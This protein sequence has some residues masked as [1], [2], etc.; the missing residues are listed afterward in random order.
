MKYNIDAMINDGLT[1]DQISQVIGYDYTSMKKDGLNQDQINQ[2]IDSDSIQS[3]DMSEK[4]PP[5]LSGETIS[6]GEGMLMHGL[7]KVADRAGKGFEIGARKIQEPILSLGA[8]SEDIAT[9]TGLTDKTPIRDYINYNQQQ[10][11]EREKE[12][13]YKEGDILTPSNVSGLATNIGLATTPIKMPKS[14]SF[15]ESLGRTGVKEMNVTLAQEIGAGKTYEEAFD[16]SAVTGAMVG[17]LGVVGAGIYKGAKILGEQKA[18]KVLRRF[19]EMLAIT[20]ERKGELVGNYAKLMGIEPDKMTNSDIVTAIAYGE[21]NARKILESSLSGKDAIKYHNIF[22]NYAKNISKRVEKQINSGSEVDISKGV[23]EANELLSQAWKDYRHIIDLHYGEKFIDIPMSSDLNKALF[24]IADKIGNKQVKEQ[25]LSGVYGGTKV[26]RLGLNEA[27]EMKQLIGDILF[28]KNKAV[29]SKEEYLGLVKDKPIYDELVSLYEK[30]LPPEAKKMYETLNKLTTLKAKAN[31]MKLVNTFREK[32]LNIV[33][34]DIKL[35]ETPLKAKQKG[36]AYDSMIKLFGKRSTVSNT[37]ER[38]VIGNMYKKASKNGFVDFNKL[39]DDV[40]SLNLKTPDGKFL[41]DMITRYNKS[42]GN[43]GDL[44]LY[45][46]KQGED[47]AGLATDPF[48]SG[49][50]AINKIFYNRLTEFAGFSRGLRASYVQKKLPSVLDMKR[51]PDDFTIREQRGALA[52][53]R[54]FKSL[55]KMKNTSAEEAELGAGNFYPSSQMIGETGSK[56]L[57]TE[58][59]FDDA[60]RIFSQSD[61][62]KDGAT[63]E[64]WEKTGWFFDNVDDRWKFHLDGNNVRLKAN[65][66]L[67]TRTGT[68]KLQDVL[69]MPEIFKAY[70]ELKDVKVHFT[71]MTSTSHK[72]WYNPSTGEIGINRDRN[73]WG[74]SMIEDVKKTLVHEIQH[75]IQGIEGFAKGGSP[76]MF[77][78]DYMTA[79]KKYQSLHGE[80]EARALTKG[81]FGRYPKEMYDEEYINNDLF[82][83]MTNYRGTPIGSNAPSEPIPPKP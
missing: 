77:N 51:M 57:G 82:R 73:A 40:E 5:D 19:E 58:Q 2:V 28:G 54:F 24:S 67:M 22:N 59:S 60:I 25:L 18:S 15:T 55:E 65:K 11:A 39:V 78:D 81:N 72:G 23:L 9:K 27:L 31:D 62:G 64:A 70:P 16:S 1:D 12:L 29:M 52:F 30:A 10:I 3:V 71:D 13:G 49:K 26:G 20:P 17:S 44:K 61:L 43:I 14:M 74:H 47:S 41:K 45:G 50:V 48:A 46:I 63:K 8:I 83:N 36:S 32:G 34:D 80:V 37:I 68:H 53:A 33:A 76:Q 56:N 75:S 38:T 6:T 21:D 4:Q 79:F 35:F 42:L 69:D 7:N 66:G